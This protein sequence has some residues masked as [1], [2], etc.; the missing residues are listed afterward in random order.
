VGRVWHS[1]PLSSL[2]F[3]LS[4]PLAPVDWSGLSLAVGLVLAEVL[5]PLPDATTPPRLGLKW[6][7]DLMLA[8]PGEAPRKLGGVLIETVSVGAS[9]LAVVGVG[10]NVRALAAGEFSTG[11][12]SLAELY[13]PGEAPDAPQVLAR[14]AKP[15]VQALHDFEHDGFAAL[16]E[17][18]ARRDLL[19]GQRVST[20][21]AD[22][23]E[24]LAEGVDATGALRVRVGGTV[25]RV[26]SGDVSVR[27]DTAA[28]PGRTAP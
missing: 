28:T 10:L 8:T 26:T 24:G 27:A 19:A 5:D 15:L 17:R 4:L 14:I 16:A 11:Q 25:R 23:P 9:R 1:A 18:F 7:N 12:A 2:T 3:S 22:L 21:L 6:P 20:T 13:P